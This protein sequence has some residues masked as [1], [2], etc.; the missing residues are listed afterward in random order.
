MGKTKEVYIEAKKSRNFQ[1]YTVGITAEV[2]ETEDENVLIKSLQTKCR[3][4]CQEQID[5]D[6][7]KT[8]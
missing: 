8:H 4:L 1:T 6:S 7:P 3:K 2:D 5:I